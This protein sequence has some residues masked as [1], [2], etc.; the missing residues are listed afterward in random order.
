MGEGFIFIYIELVHE[1]F[2][3]VEESL[4]QFR[5]QSFFGR[6]VNVNSFRARLFHE[7]FVFVPVYVIAFKVC[8]FIIPGVLQILFNEIG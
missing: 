1:V 6:T 7:L 3:F 8:V 2:R 5:E 4:I